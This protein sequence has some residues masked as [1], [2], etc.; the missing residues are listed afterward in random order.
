M[1]YLKKFRICTKVQ[2]DLPS[3]SLRNILKRQFHKQSRLKALFSFLEILGLV[4]VFSFLKNCVLVQLKQI[5]S[6]SYP[7]RIADINS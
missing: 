4:L 2:H 5:F 3:K 7:I 6:V 1:L